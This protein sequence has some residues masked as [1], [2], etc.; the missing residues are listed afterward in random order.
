MKEN[1]TC[2]L[3]G[4]AFTLECLRDVEKREGGGCET[5]RR[6]QQGMRIS[7]GECLIESG[8][9]TRHGRERT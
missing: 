4:V 1:E 5:R 7:D 8:R 6:T 3:L 2:Q 9:I